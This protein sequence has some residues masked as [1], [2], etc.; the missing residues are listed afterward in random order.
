[1]APLPTHHEGALEPACILVVDDDAPCRRLIATCLHESGYEVLS[2]ED[3]QQ[4]L[5]AV[6]A[7]PPDLAL[8][9]LKLRHASG[10][11]LVERLLDLYPELPV[12]IISAH[13][14]ISAAVEAIKRGASDFLP[15]P[16]SPDELRHLVARM[17]H[18]AGSPHDG[19]EPLRRTHPAKLLLPATT[20]EQQPRAQPEFGGNFTL[21]EI[22]RRHI[23]AL[24]ARNSNLEKVA[25][26]LG[27]NITTLWRKRK[28][29]E[30][31]DRD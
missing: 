25:K 28:K 1:M 5:I 30:G 4:A 26:T 18:G 2:A 10:L 17:T 3:A 27:I 21:E 19:M 9:D 15:K 14:A 11:D 23:L 12:V 20:D 13:P 8:V 22:E 29:Y 16:F 24:L 7:A 6:S 31:T